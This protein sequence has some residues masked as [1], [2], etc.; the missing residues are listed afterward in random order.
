MLMTALAA[1]GVGILIWALI[2]TY[3]GERGVPIPRPRPDHVSVAS[4][5]PVGRKVK[6]FAVG[7]D[8]FAEPDPL[9][10][11]QVKSDE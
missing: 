11:Y 7:P 5:K 1:V 8:P 2:Q 6:T 9:K 3:I 10:P 4:A